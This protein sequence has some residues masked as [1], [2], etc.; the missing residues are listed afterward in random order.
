MLFHTTLLFDTINGN[1]TN[2]TVSIVLCVKM[3]LAN[4]N[5]WI[6]TMNHVV[7]W[8]PTISIFELFTMQSALYGHEKGYYSLTS[9]SGGLGPANT[10]IPLPIPRL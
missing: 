3:Q 1:Q 6:E 10:L 8:K 4:E 9:L 5:V 7:Q 2:S